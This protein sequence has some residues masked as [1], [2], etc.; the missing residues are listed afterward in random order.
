MT[1]AEV[2]ALLVRYGMVMLF[3]PFSALDKILGFDHAVRQAQEVFRPRALAVAVLLAGL[4]IE[5]VCTLGVVTGTADRAAAFLIAGYC[6]ATA[7]L[8]KRFWAPG[9]FWSNPDGKGRTMF[10]DFLKNLSLGAGFLL[11]AVGTDGGGLDAFLRAPLAS[12]NP[13]RSLP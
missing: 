11:L 9:D 3:M 5:I 12:T 8:Y 2:A 4:F 1:S 7:V 13:Y 6:A 10:W